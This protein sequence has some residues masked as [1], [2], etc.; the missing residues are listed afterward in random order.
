M[1]EIKTTSGTVWT[2][3][4][5]YLLAGACLIL[6]TCGGWLIER[7]LGSH[8]A[9]QVASQAMTGTPPMQSGP[10]PLNTAQP[11]PSPQQLKEAT[12]AQ[13]APLLEQLKANPNDPA[14][15]A[16]LGNLYYDTKLY[17]TAIE[18]YER[19][20]KVQPSNASVRTDLGTAYWYSGNADTAIE[21]FNKALS[22]APNKPDTLFN[23]GIVKWQGKNDGPGAVAT[24]QKLLATNPNYE[25]KQNVLQ[26]ITQVQGH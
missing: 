5:A 15:L 2:P 14:V 25:N 11:M 6:G 3:A 22:Y 23:L 4:Q 21:Q 13:A 8:Q 19:A 18:Y 24:W 10:P 17:P 7:S 26:L 16:S 12:D 20:L 9:T 1:T